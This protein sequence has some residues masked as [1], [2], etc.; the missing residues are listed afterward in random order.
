MNF[1]HNFLQKKNKKKKTLSIYAPITGKI[2]NIFSK[3]KE[4]NKNVYQIII[5]PFKKIITAPFQGKIY[6]KFFFKKKF[7]I[8]LNPYLNIFMKLIIKK[9]I[10]Q[11]NKNYQFFAPEINVYT[12]ET[13]LVLNL[14]KNLISSFILVIINIELNNFSPKKII[15]PYTI[16][17]SG[18][19]KIF[20][21][22]NIF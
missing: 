1:F 11:K 18:Q 21:I 6:Q 12:G 3:R 7:F 8:F 17:K 4:N 15:K 2:T 14:K 5:Q 19:T 10:I 22:K 13:I 20:T 16:I 9:D